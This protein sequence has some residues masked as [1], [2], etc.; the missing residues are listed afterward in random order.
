MKPSSDVK[1]ITSVSFS[2]QSDAPRIYTA[3]SEMPAQASAE[4]LNPLA[5]PFYAGAIFPHSQPKKLS[6]DKRLNRAGSDHYQTPVSPGEDLM[7]RLADLLTQRQDRNS[8]PRPE[9][10]V[11]TGNPLRYPNWIKSFETFMERKMENPSKCLYYLGKYTTGEAKEAISGLLALDNT[12]AYNKARKILTDRFGNPFIV[13]N[14]YRKKINGWPKIPPNDGQALRKFSDFLQHCNTAMNTI[15]FL[16]V[17]N[18]PDKNQRMVKTFPSHV[19]MRWNRVVDEWLAEDDPEGCDFAVRSRR[20][21]KAGYPPFA[22]FCEFMRK[23]AR[24]VCNP[25]TSLQALKTEETKEKIDSFRDKN[26]DVR[27]F[28]TLSSKR[29]PASDEERSPSTGRSKQIMSLL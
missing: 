27:A 24:I 9:P 4:D 19:V 17:L 11:F 28:A 8:L 6:P 15:Q 26:A 13:A 12:G 7:R 21:V 29:T 20:L 5:S 1:A 16:N 18:D 23:E 3:T 10:E 22:E 25:V 14:A 2:N